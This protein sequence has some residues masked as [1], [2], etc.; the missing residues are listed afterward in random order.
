MTYRKL[1]TEKLLE[2]L[3]EYKY[4]LF[5]YDLSLGRKEKEEL[6]LEF[7]MAKK[8]ITPLLNQLKN[9]DAVQHIKLSSNVRFSKVVVQFV[10]QTSLRMLFI[11]KLMYK[12]LTYMDERAILDKRV[13][14]RKGCYVPCIE[15]QFEEAILHAYMNHSGMKDKHYR[16]FNDFHV[17]VRED[18][19]EYFNTKYETQFPTLFSLTDYQEPEREKMVEK[20]KSFPFNRFMRKMNVRWHNFMGVMRQARMI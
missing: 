14:T 1:F 8:D 19:L 16:Y 13:L 6:G 2:L 10:N 11:H 12:T 9:V 7:L 17:L 5:N 18:L 20:L 4:A 3:S 15:H